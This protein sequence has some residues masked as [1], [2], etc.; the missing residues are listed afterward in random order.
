MDWHL[1]SIAAQTIVFLLGGYAMVIRNDARSA[2]LER[3]GEKMERQLE[4]LSSVV[5][6]LAV[7]DERLNNQGHRLN[8]LEARIEAL[9]RGE[10]FITGARGVEKEYP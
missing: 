7:Q 8:L 6:E 2:S 9:R 4:A 5:T 1:V 3:Q 10:G